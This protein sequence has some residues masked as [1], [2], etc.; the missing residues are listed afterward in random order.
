V[1]EVGPLSGDALLTPETNRSGQLVDI[2]DF[3]AD[4]RFAG[5]DGT[6]YAI[7]ILDTGID[8]LYPDLVGRVDLSRSISF[9]AM[10][11]FLV[12]NFFPTRHPITD[13][14]FHGTHVA[15]TASS[16]AFILARTFLQ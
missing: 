11:D 15:M 8:Y 16:N 9:E 14:Y 13:L 4:A 12:S 2:A 7:A 1:G 6:G 5:I 3:R 10:D